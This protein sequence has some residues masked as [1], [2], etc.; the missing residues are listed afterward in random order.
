MLEIIGALSLLLSL[1]TG[2]VAIALT[3]LYDQNRAVLIIISCSTIIYALIVL[4]RLV[5]FLPIQK[6]VTRISNLFFQILTL[7]CSVEYFKEVSH[8]SLHSENVIHSRLTAAFQSLL[9]FSLFV[10][11]MFEGRDATST[12]KSSDGQI[13]DNESSPVKQYHMEERTSERFVPLKNSTQTLTP[14]MEVNLGDSE[15]PVNWLMN[16]M[17]RNTQT[18][19]VSN[20][21]VVRHQLTPIKLPYRSR[22]GSSRKS[23]D[24]SPKITGIKFSSSKLKLKSPF[25][26]RKSHKVGPV[27]DNSSISKT[28]LNNRYVTRLSTISDLP[29]S[30]LNMLS[31]ASTTDLNKASKKDERLATVLDSSDIQTA[32]GNEAGN[33]MR[34]ASQMEEERNA[35]QRMDHTLLPSFLN[36]PLREPTDI[37]NASGATESTRPDSP[38]ILQN[39][40]TNNSLIIPDLTTE[41]ADR[42][43]ITSTHEQTENSQDTIDDYNQSDLGD[44]LELSSGQFNEEPSQRSE[45]PQHIELP[46]NV[47][48]E[49]WEKNSKLFMAR[50]KQIQQEPL[51]LLTDVAE[52]TPIEDDLISPTNISANPSTNCFEFPLNKTFET[53]QFPSAQEN[54]ISSTSDAVSKLD[55]YL[56]N[57]DITE[58]AAEY[59]LEDSLRN[60]YSTSIIME[61]SYRDIPVTDKQHSPTKS[62]ISMVSSGSLTHRRSQS[63]LNNFL[64][65]T[66]SHVKTNS[67]AS[68]RFPTNST[69]HIISSST[70]SSPIKSNSFKRFGKKLSISNFHDTHSHSR[71]IEHHFDLHHSHQIEHSRGRSVDFTYVRSLQNNHSPTKSITTS[72]STANQSRRN[73]AIPERASRVVSRIFRNQSTDKTYMLDSEDALNITLRQ[74][75]DLK[76]QYDNSSSDSSRSDSQL[77]G[78][79]YPE[80]IVSEYDREKWNA[81]QNLHLINSRGEIIE[82]AE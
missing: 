70:Q 65:G 50:A 21:S 29:K 53:P 30:F 45:E 7:A 72:L 35:V 62:L 58:E 47:T 43:N 48:L 42:T 57:L 18:E 11:G 14:G 33:R 28:N 79:A 77:S 60:D 61:Q 63:T 15:H 54:D 56:N 80:N 38:L 32:T 23:T 68:F 76:Q 20:S 59:M 22:A 24:S 51:G 8:H 41:A 71:S 4:L 82:Q 26:I 16:E 66:T 55:E 49:M 31:S 36:I 6:T 9:I 12:D 3:A 2:A 17:N 67:Q 25:K 52:D 39:E 13:D 64:N 37:R 75:Q 34:S 78:S 73:S 40:V 5:L 19:E 74:Q 10:N 44:I 46:G 1:S 81:L 27:N 69:N